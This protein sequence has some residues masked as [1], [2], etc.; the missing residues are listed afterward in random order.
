MEESSKKNVK[1]SNKDKSKRLNI[2]D[3][4]EEDEAEFS[5]ADDTYSM[6]ISN[7][8]KERENS[9]KILTQLKQTKVLND[10]KKG[11][12]LS[13]TH[14]SEYVPTSSVASSETASKI[15]NV[16]R[17]AFDSIQNAFVPLK[18]S[19]KNIFQKSIKSERFRI[20]KPKA[21][22]GPL[23]DSIP[24]TLDLSHY[25][26]ASSPYTFCEFQSLCDK[27]KLI[28]AALDT[29]HSTC[30]IKVLINS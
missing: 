4:V 13:T 24:N 26:D 20:M 23:T 5:L 9:G 3:W 15:S 27:E 19:L 11:E 12:L 21:S 2:F 16:E 18:D 17:Q 7:Y 30:I 22:S 14:I 1:D 6:S 8:S 29:C 10:T 25:T 28:I